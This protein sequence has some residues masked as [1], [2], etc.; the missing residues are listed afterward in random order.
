[1]QNSLA[2]AH[3]W[4]RASVSL[5]GYVRNTFVTNRAD[6]STDPGS[7]LYTQYVPTHENGVIADWI[8]DSADSTFEVRGDG[9]FVG[10]VSN[11]YNAANVLTTTG[12]GVQ[13]ISDLA[14]QNTWRYHRGE[15]I[16][17]IDVTSIFLPDGSLTQRHNDRAR[18]AHR[19]GALAAN[20]HPL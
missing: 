11:Q 14:V 15:A 4:A 13:Q 2:F 7:L 9:R 10:G 19:P 20:C 18:A 16:A 17:G 3:A 5:T 8:V 1:M 6:K 12:S